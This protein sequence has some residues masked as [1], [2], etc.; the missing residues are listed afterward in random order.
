M[1]QGCEVDMEG[2]GGEW[3]WGALCKMSNYVKGKRRNKDF[4][5]TILT[6]YVSYVSKFEDIVLVSSFLARYPWKCTYILCTYCPK[7]ILAFQHQLIHIFPSILD[8]LL[9]ILV[10]FGHSLPI[11]FLISFNIFRFTINWVYNQHII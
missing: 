8:Y 4:K 6:F 7:H 5:R 10:S 1:L 3:D 11:I 2:L 9:N